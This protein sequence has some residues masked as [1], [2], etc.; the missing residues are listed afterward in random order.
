MIDHLQHVVGEFQRRWDEFD[1]GIPPP[2][3]IP[4]VPAARKRKPSASAAALQ[5]VASRAQGGRS[6]S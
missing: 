3:A 5:S 1:D 2:I 6:P 4:A